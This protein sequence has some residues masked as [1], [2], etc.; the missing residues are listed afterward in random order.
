[1]VENV[2]LLFKDVNTINIDRFGFL[3]EWLHEAND[4]KGYWNQLVKCLL[5]PD[6]HLPERPE[7][8]GPLL[9]WWAQHAHNRQRPPTNND[10][11]DSNDDN[12]VGRRGGHHSESQGQGQHQPAPSSRAPPLMHEHRLQ[13]TPLP[14]CST[15][16][17]DGSATWIFADRSGGACS[18]CSPSSDL[19]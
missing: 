6:T 17:N 15:I 4:N 1:M 2:H 3:R 12:D 13:F 5:H 8:W 19:D 9:S 18:N 10:D 14:P 11:D 16:R 7:T